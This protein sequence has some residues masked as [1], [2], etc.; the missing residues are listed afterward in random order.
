MTK[1]LI[2]AMAAALLVVGVAVGA[3]GGGDR[4]VTADPA[5]STST[6]EAPGEVS[7]PCDEAEHANDPRCTGAASQQGNSGPGRGGDDDRSRRSNSGPGGG[8][9][10]HSGRGRGGDDS[11]DSG[12][13]SGRGSGRSGGED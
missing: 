5:A 2:A 8:G 13:R 11:D 1:F 12:S 4:S 3:P 6:V 10:D 9:G 7:G